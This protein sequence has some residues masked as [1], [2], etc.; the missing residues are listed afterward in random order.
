MTP[1]Q[2][3]MAADRLLKDDTLRE[4]LDVIKDDAVGVFR[5]PNASQE[6]IMEA[7]RMVRALD[8]FETKLRAFVMDGELAKRRRK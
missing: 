8:A 5:Y 6:E 1:E 2:R 4:A 7:H 3:G